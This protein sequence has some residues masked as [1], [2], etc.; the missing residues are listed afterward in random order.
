MINDKDRAAGLT[1]WGFTDARNAVECPRCKAAAGDFCRQPK[2]RKAL[3]PHPERMNNY[4]T[5]IGREEF[6]R[7]HSSGRGQ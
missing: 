4:I 7:R 1:G 3:Y 2:G 6:L 5:V